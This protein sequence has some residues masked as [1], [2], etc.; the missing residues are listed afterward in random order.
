MILW[1]D[2]TA[3]AAGSAQSPLVLVVPAS[4]PFTTIEALQRAICAPM[5][6]PPS[7]ASSGPAGITQFGA[8]V[9]LKRAG[10]ASRRC[11]CPYRGG[12]RR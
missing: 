3:I 2:F 1:A 7:Y 10:G 8:E 9:Y 5:P 12:P 4:K 6:P 11:T